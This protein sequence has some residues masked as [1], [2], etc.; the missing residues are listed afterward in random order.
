LK[1]ALAHR[2]GDVNTLDVEGFVKR[3]LARGDIHGNER[4]TLD[5]DLADLGVDSITF[6]MLALRVNEEYGCELTDEDTRKLFRC[7]F[8]GDVVDLIRQ[9]TSDLRTSSAGAC[10]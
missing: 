10:K 3:A 1:K 4:V 5:A 9:I 7:I 8:V 6:V 2:G